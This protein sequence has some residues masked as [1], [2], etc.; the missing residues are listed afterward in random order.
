M[1]LSQSK[2]L[3]TSSKKL[4]SF[5]AERIQRKLSELSTDSSVEGNCSTKICVDQMRL[6][7]AKLEARLEYL[8]KLKMQPYLLA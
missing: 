8:K 6:I 7:Q 1:A 3:L 4:E 2:Q 5:L